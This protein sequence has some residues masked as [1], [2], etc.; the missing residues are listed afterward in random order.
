MEKVGIWMIDGHFIVIKTKSN[1]LCGE[2]RM[3][4]DLGTNPNRVDIKIDVEGSATDSVEKI[5][6]AVEKGETFIEANVKLDRNNCYE[7]TLAKA[8]RA[9][10]IKDIRYG[11][12]SHHLGGGVGY[13]IYKGKTTENYNKIGDRGYYQFSTTLGELCHGIELTLVENLR[14][15]GVKSADVEFSNFDAKSSS[16]P[17]VVTLCMDKKVVK[18]EE[19]E[20]KITFNQHVDT[21]ALDDYLLILEGYCGATK[22]ELSALNKALE[23]Q[24]IEDLEPEIYNFMAQE[25]ALRT[26]PDTHYSGGEWMEQDE[27]FYVEKA[28]LKTESVKGA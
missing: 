7:N 15:Y 21:S 22:Q 1:I 3:S 12:M 17:L 25:Y 26:M 24:G 13:T 11:T 2:T 14:K 20:K 4:S 8:L 16:V 10:G 9:M 6:A 5:I 19:A 27:S 23:E 18:G 28:G